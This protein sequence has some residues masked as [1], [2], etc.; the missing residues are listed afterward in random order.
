ME[1]AEVCVFITEC[2]T[3]IGHWLDSIGSG[4]DQL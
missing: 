1:E 2:I 3:G 4:Y